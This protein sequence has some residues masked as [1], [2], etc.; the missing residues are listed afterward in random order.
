M[1]LTTPDN[2]LFAASEITDG[3][4]SLHRGNQSLSLTSRKQFLN[5]LGVELNQCISMAALH[6][7]KVKQVTE[8]DGGKG[9]MI[10][11][12]SYTVDALFTQ[13]PNLSLFLIVADCIPLALYDLKTKSFALIHGSRKSLD[14]GIIEKTIDALKENFKVEPERMQAIIGPSIGPCC[15]LLPTIK[16]SKETKWDQFI[17]QKNEEYSI[18]IWGSAEHTLRTSGIPVQNILNQKICTYHSNQY[19]SHRKSMN[20]KLPNDYRFATVCGFKK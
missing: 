19:F 11:N 16:R 20:E 12:E 5:S 8:A 1:K 15:Y 6:E 18:D 9:M 14:A 10:L 13:E 2:F 7:D 17:H 3:N 4:M